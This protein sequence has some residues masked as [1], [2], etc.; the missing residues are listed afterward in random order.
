[1]EFKSGDFL[2]LLKEAFVGRKK[3]Q[4]DDQRGKNGMEKTKV[5][6]EVN[7]ELLTV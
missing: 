4:R 3:N 2:L 6:K 5:Q 7:L 1:M